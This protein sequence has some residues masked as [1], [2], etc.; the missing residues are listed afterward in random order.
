MYTS[1][2]SS[3]ANAIAYASAYARFVL[4]S[5]RPTLLRQLPMCLLLLCGLLHG[6]LIAADEG[7]DAFALAA[8][9]Y[10]LGN[11]EN[12]ANGFR[13]MVAT[14]PDHPRSTLGR[15]FLGESLVQLGMYEEAHDYFVQFASSGEDG[16]YLGQAI[17]RVGETAFLTDDFETAELWLDR[18]HREHEGNDLAAYS[19]PYLGDVYFEQEKLRDAKRSYS[20]ALTRHPETPLADH[21]RFGIA[22]ILETEGARSEAIRFFT[23]IAEGEG[24]LADDSIFE[25]IRLSRDAADI[26][27]VLE[28]ANRYEGKM[29]TGSFSLAFQYLVAEA[30]LATGDTEAAHEIIKSIAPRTDSNSSGLIDDVAAGVVFHVAVSQWEQSQHDQAIPLLERVLAQWP[31][32]E[33]GD[34]SLEMLVRIAKSSNDTATLGQLAQRFQSDY[35][36]SPLAPYVLELLG[37]NQ[38]DAGDYLAARDSFRLAATSIESIEVEPA[39]EANI[40]YLLGLALIATDANEEAIESLTRALPLAEEAQEI[41]DLTAAPSRLG[42]GIHMALGTAHSRLENHEAAISHREAFLLLETEGRDAT[43][44]AAELAADYLANG[45]IDE[46]WHWAKWV[47]VNAAKHPRLES[48]IQKIGE[49]SFISQDWETAKGAFEY[50]A[51]QSDNPELIARGWSGSA[52]VAYQTEDMEAAAKAF[53]KVYA[54][55]PTGETAAEACYMLGRL[56]QDTDAKLAGEWYSKVFAADPTSRH[57]PESQLKVARLLRDSGT[58]EDLAASLQAYT[59]LLETRPD[60]NIDRQSDGTDSEDASRVDHEPLA[61]LDVVLYERAWLLRSL[62]R[63]NDALRD[64]QLLVEQYPESEYWSDTAFRLAELLSQA[65]EYGNA[66]QL[67]VKIVKR[68]STDSASTEITPYA[69][70]LLSQNAIHQQEW[71]TALEYLDSLLSSDA[72][73]EMQIAATYWKGEA[74]FRLD[75]YTPAVACFSELI[76]DGT[77]TDPS[78]RPTVQLRFAQIEA[79]QGRWAEALQAA[80][81]IAPHRSQLS[82][83][84]EL[85][86]LIGRCCSALGRFSEAREAYERVVQSPTG[87]KTETAAKAQWMIGESYFHQDNYEEAIAAFERVEVLYG[88][89]QWQSAALLQAGKCHSKSGDWKQ[90]VKLFARLIREYPESDFAAEAAELLKTAQ[91]QT[92]TQR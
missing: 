64:F 82:Q 53:E 5:R 68:S 78:W 56:T 83:P 24:D 6:S 21:C 38:Y 40:L 11:W 23:L 87:S 59:S 16:P 51:K 43:N 2:R 28:V 46:A 32:S 92:R 19:W 25:L 91:E 9:Q 69:I 13:Q 42:I 26:D 62:D 50:L 15:F 8:N 90:A 85:D 29:Q 71:T 36:G 39:F 37:R 81:D 52:W 22:R 60:L 74:H 18:F 12:A 58:A 75:Q 61:E 44:C 45:Q 27:S 14:Y 89:P 88:Y 65:G 20:E 86:Y 79:L 34:D 54:N 48:V 31:Q 72:P 67:L 57:A 77:A 84:F 7:D 80:K 73:S 3:P 55:T 30:N 33:W 41:S 35:S 17:Y 63:E 66:N 70:Y 4:R 76:A 47:A 10:S 49:S 1:R